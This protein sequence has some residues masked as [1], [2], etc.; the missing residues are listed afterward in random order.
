MGAS[1]NC[2]ADLVVEDVDCSFDYIWWEVGVFEV[3]GG[4][5][6]LSMIKWKGFLGYTLIYTGRKY[7]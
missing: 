2:T 5:E 6:L 7:L 1:P 4:V 3:V